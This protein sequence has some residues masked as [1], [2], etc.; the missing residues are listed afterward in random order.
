MPSNKHNA[1]TTTLTRDAAGLYLMAGGDTLLG[2]GT[3]NPKQ[4]V[5]RAGLGTLAELTVKA[6]LQGEK[7]TAALP[8]LP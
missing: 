6:L 3:S 1:Q 8:R 4:I 7:P 5:G 2:A